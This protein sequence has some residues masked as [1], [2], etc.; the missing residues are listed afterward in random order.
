MIAWITGAGRGIGKA[1]A[2]RLAKD[3]YR[4]AATGR[5]LIAQQAVA[6][7][8]ISGGGSAAAVHCDVA[9]A[10]S[11]ASAYETIRAEFGEVDLLVNNAGATVFKSFLSTGSDEFDLLLSTNLRGPFLCTQAV[12][13][14][15]MERGAGTIV[16]INSMTSKQVFRDSSIYAATKAG[17]KAMTDCLRL[18]VRGSGVRV[19]SIYPGATDTEIWPARVREKHGN[20]MMTA[21]DVAEQVHHAVSMPAHMLVEDIVVQPIG[22]PL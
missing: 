7:A 20:R 11:V 6:H 9:D 4:V 15:M 17:L 16:M 3:G 8:I 5:D 12:L 22:G 21:A 18:E 10:A 13:P 2:L 14:V 19:I 1:I